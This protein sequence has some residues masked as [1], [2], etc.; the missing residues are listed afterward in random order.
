MLSAGERVPEV[1]VWTGPH[2]RATLVDL[3]GY[4]PVFLLFY[5]FD[6]TST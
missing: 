5:L 3:A 4:G 2:E 1:E 6:W